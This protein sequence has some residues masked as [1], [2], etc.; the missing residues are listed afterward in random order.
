MRGFFGG[1]LSWLDIKIS[2]VL[3]LVLVFSLVLFANVEGD[4]YCGNKKE[5]IYMFAVFLIS[6][7]LILLSML[8]A[9]TSISSSKISGVQGRYFLC[10]APLLCMATTTSLVNVSEEKCRKVWMTVIATEILIV[11]QIVVGAM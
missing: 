4:K 5:R 9:F 8:V 3:L 1:L 6:L 2:W 7:V 11:L 10:I